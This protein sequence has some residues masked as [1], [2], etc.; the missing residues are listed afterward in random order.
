MKGE[1]DLTPAVCGMVLGSIPMIPPGL[2]DWVRLAG[3]ALSFSSMAFFLAVH[4]V[5]I[6]G[7]PRE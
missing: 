3:A 1:R 6:H 4:L 5:R 7:S 2:P